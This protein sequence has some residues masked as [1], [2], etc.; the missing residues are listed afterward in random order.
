V[1]AAAK[2]ATAVEVAEGKVKFMRN[3]EPIIVGGCLPRVSKP[4]AQGRL[5]KLRSLLLSL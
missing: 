2:Q 1:L 4:G 3:R 5:G